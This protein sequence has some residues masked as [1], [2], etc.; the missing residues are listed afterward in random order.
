M[1][2]TQ[3][4]QA[5]LATIAAAS[6]PGTPLASLLELAKVKYDFVTVEL[7]N[8]SLSE[9]EESP[10]TPTDSGTVE[11]TAAV[12][13]EKATVATTQEQ[14]DS[15]QKQPPSTATKVDAAPPIKIEWAVAS[16]IPYIYREVVL[17]SNGAPGKPPIKLPTQVSNNNLM[18]GSAV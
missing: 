10:A 14:S 4:A 6:T 17:R 18:S 1:Q 11:K 2:N 15:E 7:A 9:P 13:D 8:S 12:S 16:M 5:T 3:S